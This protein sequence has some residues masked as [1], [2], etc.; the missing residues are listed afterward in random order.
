M[1]VASQPGRLGIDNPAKPLLLLLAGPGG[2][3][4]PLPRVV[5]LLDD[6]RTIVRGLAAGER[7][8]LLLGKYPE[9]V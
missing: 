2:Q 6:G 7:R 8:R 1:V 3:T 4:L 5:N 9:L